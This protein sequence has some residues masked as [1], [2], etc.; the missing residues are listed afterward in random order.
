MNDAHYK[1]ERPLANGQ[2]RIDFQTAPGRY[3]HWKLAIDGDVAT[4]FLDVDEKGALFEGYDL[5]LNSYDLGVDIELADAIER[6][7][8]EHPEV[9]VLVLRSGKPRV[10]CAGANIRMLAGASH[11]HKVNFCKFTNETRNGIEDLSE[12]SGLKTVCAISGTAAGGGYELALAADHI[13][14]VDDGSSAV[15]LPE[16][17]LLAVLP[18]TGG[19]TRVADKRKVRRDYADVFC[20]TEEGVKGK[21]A[22]EWRLVDEV[23][24][25]SKFDETIAARAKEFAAKSGRGAA[26]RGITLVPLARSFTADGVE[27]GSLAVAFERAGR[28]A[29]V[30]L[31]GPAVSPPASVEAMAALGAEFWPLKLAR[32]LDDAILNIR[33]NEFDVAAIVFKSSGDP[34]EVMAYEHFL[35]ANKDHWLVREIRHLWKRVLKRID[36]TSRSLVTLLEP[37]SCFVGTLAEI[38]FA[39]DRSYMLIGARGGDNKPPAT[40]ALA[41]ANF[42][43]YPMSNGL[44]RLASRFLASPADLAAAKAEHEKTLD[45]ETAQ[46]LGLVTFAL[47]DIDWDDEVR[48]FLEERASFSPDSLTGL[49]A[50]LRFAG[51]ETMES[52]IFAR[53]SAWQNWIFQRPNAVGEDGA[54]KRYGTGQ[55]PV[56]DTKRV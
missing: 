6:L 23:V 12:N 51:P 17:P 5:K 11:A 26:G 30:T 2:T 16:L 50:N 20:T 10:F 49:E 33:L 31:R 34:A 55:K 47:D 52:K 14:L 43:A 8:F 24:P 56:F 39:S 42:G 18:G 46:R 3:R 22:V 36:L 1:T 28:I 41:D 4:L 48:V 53:L 40:M 29:T 13:M 15:A 21:R 37:G 25:G 7:R 9:R 44:T 32:E 19:V 45:A 54:L 27:Y 38:S 35:D